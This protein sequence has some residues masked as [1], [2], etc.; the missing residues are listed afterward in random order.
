VN[1][2]KGLPA[3][4]W[5]KRKSVWDFT[6]SHRGAL[7]SKRLE[8]YLGNDPVTFKG[9]AVHVMTSSGDEQV[10]G[11]LAPKGGP[12]GSVFPAIV[13]HT[14]GEG[15][16]VYFAAGFDSAYYL[17]PYPY[18]R[19]LLAQAVAWAARVPP[20]VVVEAPMCVHAV[21]MRQRKDGERLVVHLYNDVNTTAF[22]ALPNEDVPLREE[23]L[24]IHGIKV[25]FKGYRL[26]R[27]RIEPEGISLDG[28]TTPDGT[29]VIVP[30]LR[31][32]SMVVAEIH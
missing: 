4:Y 27:I 21:A 1:F 9:Q 18:H 31:V 11:M 28:E 2:A 22:H 13:T 24:P 16:V 26:G 10:L 30:I 8:E 23:T 14:F 3:D 7:Q 5:D 19:L 25:T 29:Q 6:R 20:P 12:A 15:R 32:H 17:Y